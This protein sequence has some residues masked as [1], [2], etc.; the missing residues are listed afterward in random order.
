MHGQEGKEGETGAADGVVSDF[1]RAAAELKAWTLPHPCQY[2][3]LL[4]PES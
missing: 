1:E 4:K 2:E 3:Y